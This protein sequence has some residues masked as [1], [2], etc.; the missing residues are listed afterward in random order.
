V[1]VCVCLCVCS[2][3]I[4]NAMQMQISLS[5]RVQ[6]YA[7][8]SLADLSLFFSHFYSKMLFFDSFLT[9][10]ELKLF[11]LFFSSG[12]QFSHPHPYYYSRMFYC[13]FF[14]LLNLNKYGFIMPLLYYY[15]YE[16]LHQI[17]KKQKYHQ[18]MLLQ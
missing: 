4:I 13:L 10:N 3:F 15:T 7:I 9:T 12:M 2:Y 5:C 18:C 6:N 14:S 16:L 11:C 8:P 1:C 17:V